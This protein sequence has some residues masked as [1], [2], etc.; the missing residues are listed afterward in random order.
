M[1]GTRRVICVA[2]DRK[3]CEQALKL[4]LI[5]LSRHNARTP[6]VVFYPPADQII[7]V[8]ECCDYFKL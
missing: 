3:S 5:G 6:V 1:M 4:L 7:I 8:P 2:E